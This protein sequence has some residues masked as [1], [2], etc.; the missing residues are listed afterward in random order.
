MI[1]V[2]QPF[3][4]TVQALQALTREERRRGRRM[5]PQALTVGVLGA[6]RALAVRTRQDPTA[7]ADLLS[8]NVG[9]GFIFISKPDDDCYVR[10]AKDSL[11]DGATVLHFMATGERWIAKAHRTVRRLVADG[12]VN[13][14]ECAMGKEAIGERDAPA[15]V[16]TVLRSDV[17]RRRAS[18]EVWDPGQAEIWERRA[19]EFAAARQE[20]APSA[21][22]AN[23]PVAGRL[24]DSF[25][26]M[27]R[28]RQ[29]ALHAE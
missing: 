5:V 15:V 10:Y 6:L 18:A 29:A 7:D 13:V 8:R 21:E 24:L 28:D 14:F 11:R 2:G 19:D 1:T 3:Q 12:E 4:D 23:T 20:Q 26:R 16:V 17:L 27:G 25:V 9:M 22:P